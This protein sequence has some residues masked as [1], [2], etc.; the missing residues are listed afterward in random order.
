MRLR[1]Y[2]YSAAGLYFVTVCTDGGRC[3]FGEITADKMDLNML[4][5][6]VADCWRAIPAHFP[7]VAL[8]RFVVMPNHVH[9]IVQLHPIPQPQNG[10]MNRALR[11]MTSLL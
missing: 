11:K 7:T 2:D 10:A 4:G 1:N 5:L 8:D 9:G 6:I 3:L